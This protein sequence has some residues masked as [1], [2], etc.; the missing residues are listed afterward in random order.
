MSLSIKKGQWIGIIGES[1]AGKSSIFDLLLRLYEPQG[2]EILIDGIAIKS[3][4]KKT[5]RQ[6]I[7]KVS[8]Q[9]EFFNG[10]IKDN[11]LLVNEGSSEEDINKVLLTV[12]L[13]GLIK[14]T[15]LGIESPIG[16]DGLHFSGGERQRLSIAQGMI[17]LVKL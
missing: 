17:G 12:L 4:N 8:Q 9:D 11:L 6:H 1:G 14:E 15:D 10:T 2:G 16:K 7:T 3:I 5:I 13:D